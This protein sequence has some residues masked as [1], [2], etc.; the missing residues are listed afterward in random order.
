MKVE[1]LEEFKIDEATNLQIQQLLKESFSD[2]PNG[3]SYYKQVPCFRF[4]VWEEKQLIGHMAV[5]FRLIN[6]GGVVAR[7]F[8]VIDLCVAVAF[9]SKKIGS[10]L[11]NEL[12]SLGKTSNIDFL[13]LIAKDQEV[14]KKN[15][16]ESADNS[17]RWLLINNHQTFGVGQRGLDNS[18][19][20]KT[21][22]TKKWNEGTLDFLGHVF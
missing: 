18:L 19:M 11:L 16:F 4:L 10:K 5:E 21:L 20:V 6:V 22:G 12:E 15:G 9:Q 2:Y 14:Y 7:I 17:C 3:R 8:G 13:L 1:R